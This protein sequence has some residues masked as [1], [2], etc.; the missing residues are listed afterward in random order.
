MWNKQEEQ[1]QDHSGNGPVD[2]FADGL[3]DQISNVERLTREL[4]R[5]RPAVRNESAL[6]VAEESRSC[7]KQPA[8]LFEATQAVFSA[9]LQVL[10][11]VTM[12]LLLQPSPLPWSRRN[13]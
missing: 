7:I 11:G 9:S 5:S 3:L 12:L 10:M 4:K 8:L 13:S 1:K 2:T 6:P